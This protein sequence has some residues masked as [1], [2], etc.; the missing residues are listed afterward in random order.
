[1][2]LE[3]KGARMLS[4]GKGCDSNN[5][6]SEWVDAIFLLLFTKRI[7]VYTTSLNRL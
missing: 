7:L 6:V 1:M 3:Y 5:G 2:L 4:A